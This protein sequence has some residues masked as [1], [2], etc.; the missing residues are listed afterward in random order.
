LPL[1]RQRWRRKTCFPAVQISA[2]TSDAGDPAACDMPIAEIPD[3]EGDA[4]QAHM[5]RGD[6]QLSGHNLP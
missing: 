1:V 4:R 3:L 6:L 5:A 2:T